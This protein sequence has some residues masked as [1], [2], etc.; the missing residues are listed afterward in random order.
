MGLGATWHLTVAVLL[1]IRFQ[2]LKSQLPRRVLIRLCWALELLSRPS[3][4]RHSLQIPKPSGNF[5]CNLFL[6]KRSRTANDETASSHSYGCAH[7]SRGSKTNADVRLDDG[8]AALRRTLG[9][10]FRFPH[11]TRQLNVQV[12]FSIGA[13]YPQ[14][15][16]KTGVL[17]VTGTSGFLSSLGFR[18]NGAGA[19]ATIPIMN[20]PGMFP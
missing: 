16:G 13:R 14:T 18:F 3:T 5:H 17:Y 4:Y 8:S 6:R 10:K 9:L 15:I 20:W 7:G 19:F 1:T 12:A 11:I 2:L